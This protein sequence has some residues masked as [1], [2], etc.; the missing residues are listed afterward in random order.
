[1]TSEV[2]RPPRLRDGDSVAVVS[3]SWGGPSVFPRVF[4]LGLANLRELFGLRIVEYPTT[5]ATPEQ[6]YQNP[7][8]RAE[9]LN[10]ALAD[11]RVAAVISSIGGEESVRILPYV[12]VELALANPKIVLGFSDTTTVLTLLNQRGLCTFNGPSVLAGFASMRRLPEQYVAHVRRMLFEEFDE[13]EYRPYDRY[14]VRFQPWSDP[15]YDGHV[16][17]APNDSGFTWLSGRGVHRG[18][19]F[20][21]CI[22]VLEFMKGTEFW[23][24]PSFWDGRVLF[25][26]TSEDKP[27]PAQVG[28]ML[29]NYG[30]QGIFDRISGLLI[31]R[32]YEYSDAEKVELR[33]VV[34]RIA[35]EEFGRPELPIVTDMDFGHDQPQLILPNGGLIEID[36]DR[37]RVLLVESPVK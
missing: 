36:C 25:L 3:L 19:L 31:A 27:S 12:D 35:A 11:P 30:M 34:A 26:E 22:E 16:E 1:M 20:G 24:E 21:G 10:R 9:D 14:A 4:E 32:P 37:H 23:P 17:L 8:A 33:K 13:L 29:R 6:L 5:R 7:R 15:G 2:V 28:Y 18:R